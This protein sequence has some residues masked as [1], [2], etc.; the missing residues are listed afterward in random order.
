MR[1]Y[2]KAI[3]QLTGL[4][5]PTFKGFRQLAKYLNKN[6]FA[7][8]VYEI[9]PPKPLHD[10]NINGFAI[11]SQQLPTGIIHATLTFNGIIPKQTG[12]QFAK[13]EFPVVLITVIEPN[14]ASNE[15]YVE[16]NPRL[17]GNIVC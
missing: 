15:S 6:G 14:E 10:L 1:C 11:V 9:T 4:D 7:L 5:V 3:G 8:G 13:P 12:R 16:E 17:Y 2:E